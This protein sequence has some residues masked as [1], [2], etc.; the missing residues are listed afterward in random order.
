MAYTATVYYVDPAIDANSGAGT[1]GDP[2]GD[3]QYALDTVT[4]NASNGD[5]FCIKSGT[6]ENLSANL[7]LSTYGTPAA[8]QPLI[9]QGYDAAAQD[10]GIGVLNGGGGNFQMVGSTAI[11]GLYLFDLEFKNLS[12]S[13][14]SYFALL[15]NYG[16]VINCKFTGPS[17][18]SLY[19]WAGVYTPIIYCDF[20]DSGAY[21]CASGGYGNV[22]FNY[23]EQG[24]NIATYGLFAGTG[25]LVFG[26]I[27]NWGTNA[28]TTHAMNTYYFGCVV[29]NNSF[30]RAN[31]TGQAIYAASSSA[32]G[33]T[34]INNLIEGFS[35]GV[36]DN[37]Y[38]FAL[39]RN[40]A[41]Y[42]TTT[43]S[44][45]NDTQHT[46]PLAADTTLDP[47]E[48]LTASPFR[49]APNGDFRP[50]QVDGIGAQFW[51]KHFRDQAAH[52]MNLWIGAVQPHKGPTF[53]ATRRCGGRAA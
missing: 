15:D 48:V 47:V 38:D 3:L 46:A 27:F 10:G 29:S 11:D 49:D 42:N 8:Y 4:R 41:A 7:D 45:L 13:S 21:H 32:Y 1:L 6:D 20:I 18:R 12:T 9:L 36:D 26:N 43:P 37:T 40:N 33:S 39:C 25:N 35:I 34:I 14:N 30:Y 16:G 2:Y 51:P 19:T 23:F 44:I 5:R 24:P 28:N 53:G 17:Y 52:A 31:A 50:V 22:L